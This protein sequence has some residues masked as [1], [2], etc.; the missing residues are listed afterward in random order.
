M[1]KGKGKQRCLGNAYIAGMKAAMIMDTPYPPD[2][3]VK[4][5]IRTLQQAGVSVDLFTIDFD[6]TGERLGW[7]GT[8]LERTRHEAVEIWRL[9]A[10]RFW[11]KLSALVHSTPLF[12]WWLAPRI[13]D[14][15]DASRPDL[16]HIHDMVIAP[17][18]MRV[19]KRSNL[20]VILDLHEDRPQILPHYPHMQRK[21]ARALIRPR[22]WARAQRQLMQSADRVILVT[23]EAKK[24]ALKRDHIAPE[25]VIV[26]PNVVW[27]GEFDVGENDP[28]R[29]G[30]D[31]ARP[32]RLLYI[33]DT[34]IRRGTVTILEA[35]KSLTTAHCPVTLSMVGDSSEH[36]HLLDLA[37]SLGIRD[38][39]DWVGW[40]PP[41]KLPEY[42]AEAD[43]GLS[44]L[45]RNGHHDTTFANKLFQY[46]A[47]G[48]PVIVSDCPAQADLVRSESCG[49]I[50]RAGDVH[51]LASQIR[52]MVDHP[53]EGR[54]MGQRAREAIQ[55]RWNWSITG[56]RLTNLYESLRSHTNEG[57]RT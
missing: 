50:H 21:I 20:P 10:G 25:K 43:V 42:V 39:I 52:W 9:H 14:F 24:V 38:R 32:L 49:R 3:R 44:P 16:V 13:R 40:V 53:D 35:V 4:N 1:E 15:L 56:R 7:R 19:A 41:E 51:A 36:D 11:Y 18:G 47:G 5:E 28:A 37:H 48:L 57:S 34:S 55:L 33:G 22:R 2:A 27:P 54:A 31:P 46:M 12:S 45:L 30:S 17:A 26:L 6:V 23:D 29:E 8:R